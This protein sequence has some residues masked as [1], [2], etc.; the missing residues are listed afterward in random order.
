MYDLESVR[1]RE[2]EA[3]K[4]LEKCFERMS[5]VEKEL[6]HV[7]N[8][9]ESEGRLEKELWHLRSTME[10]AEK[11]LKEARRLQSD[12]CFCSISG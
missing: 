6:L 5:V 7:E 12:P 2:Q 11:I 3:L 1:S 9:P 10:D 4:V 8:D